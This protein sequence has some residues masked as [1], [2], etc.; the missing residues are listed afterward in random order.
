M[1]RHSAKLAVSILRPEPAMALTQLFVHPLKSCRGNALQRA[2][3]TPQGLRDDRVWL[4][5]RAD[6]QFISAR[7]HPRLVQVGVTRQADGQWCFTAPEMPPLLTSPA[8]YRQRVPATVWKSA[9]S[10]LHGDAAADAWLSHYL[11]EPLQ[12]LWLGESTR[13]QKTTADRLSFADGYP[14]LLLSEASLLDL[15]SRLAQP[16][17]MALP[18]QSGGGR[19]LRL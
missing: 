9:F 1:T 10:A 19:H 3:V 15:N 12:L 4:A 2:E 11:G 16:V 17:T 6:G 18:P 13:V 7:S 14:Y 5:S 8:D